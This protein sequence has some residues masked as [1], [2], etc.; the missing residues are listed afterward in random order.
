LELGAHDLGRRA[1][2]SLSAAGG[3]AAAVLGWGWWHAQ[4]H[5]SVHVAVNDVGQT[6]PSSRWAALKVGDLVLRDRTGRALAHSR[7]TAPQGIFEFTD[8]AAGDCGRFA[9]QAPY[10]SAA[11]SGWQNCFAV[12]SRW[13]ARWAGDVVSANVT[14]GTCHIANVPVGTRR[15]TDWWLWWVPLPHVGGTPY[16]HY[17]FELFIDSTTCAAAVSPAP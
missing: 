7:A 5:A 1:R 3:L 13:Q 6:T 15:D 2:L 17:T 11:R 16:T 9:R 12:L 8:A 4:T 14:T 10:D